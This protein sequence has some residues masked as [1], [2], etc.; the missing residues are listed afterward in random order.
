MSEANFSKMSR[1]EL[2]EYVLKHRDEDTA[3]YAYVDKL[4]EEGNWV[5]MP[6]IE[7]I[8]DLKN[9]PKFIEKMRKQS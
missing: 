6:P 4:N 1:K 3:F 2:R 9:Y 8:D 7:S 5:E